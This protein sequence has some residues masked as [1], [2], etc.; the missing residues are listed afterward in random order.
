MK[1]SE[2]TLVKLLKKGDQKAMNQFYTSYA[3]ALFALTLR[4][5]RSRED[6]ED[7]LQEALLK[8]IKHLSQFTYSFEGSLMAWMKRIVVNECLGQLRK[9]E[10]KSF[11]HLMSSEDFTEATENDEADDFPQPQPEVLIQAMQQ[12]PAGY[13]TVLNLHVF[14]QM[15][16][17]EI[18]QLLNISETTSR[19]QLFKA[20]MLLRKKL[21]M[22]VQ[23][24]IHTV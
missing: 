17:K 19:S 3:P 13:R 7:M 10:G 18:A 9:T 4:Y 14:E 16:H 23:Q 15:P 11:M 20:R 2:E 1:Q 5:A 12:L 6:A 21:G 22:M 24:Q 8:G